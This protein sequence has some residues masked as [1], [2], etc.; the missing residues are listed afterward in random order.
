MKIYIC[1]RCGKQKKITTGI[2][3]TEFRNRGFETLDYKFR[4]NGIVDVCSDCNEVLQSVVDKIKEDNKKEAGKLI[5][6]AFKKTE[7]SEPFI[8]RM[9]KKLLRVG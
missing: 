8:K 7:M 9:A 2:V 6:F 4:V 5:D 1:D 3:G